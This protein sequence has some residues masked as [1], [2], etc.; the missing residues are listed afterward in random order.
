MEFDISS[1]YVDFVFLSSITDTFL[2]DYIDYT[3][4]NWRYERGHQ[5]PKIDEEQTTQWPKEKRTNNDLLNIIEKTKVRATR[6]P[7]KTMGE[8]WKGIQFLWQPSVYY[9]DYDKRNI[10]VFICDINTA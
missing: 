7:R 9:C 5:D 4:I 3:Y 8:L 1:F 10:S 2:I 6:T